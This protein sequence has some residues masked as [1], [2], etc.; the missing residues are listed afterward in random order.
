MIKAYRCLVKKFWLF[1]RILSYLF[2]LLIYLI[3]AEYFESLFNNYQFY[4]ALII[5]R[6]RLVNCV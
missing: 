3:E 5:L 6:W 2:N 4:K 1:L